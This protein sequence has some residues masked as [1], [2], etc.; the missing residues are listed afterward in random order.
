MPKLPFEL[1]PL[2]AH[3]YCRDDVRDGSRK[4]KQLKS[5]RDPDL[6]KGS[7]R[8]RWTD[9]MRGVGHV[10]RPSLVFSKGCD[11]G[12]S[13][14]TAVLISLAAFTINSANAGESWKGK[15]VYYKKNSTANV[16]EKN[17][18]AQGVVGFPE[19]VLEEDGDWVTLGSARMRKEYLMDSEEAYPY[20]SNLANKD[21]GDVFAWVGFASCQFERGEFKRSIKSFSRAIELA[22]DVA[23]THVNR[24]VA[25]NCVHDFEGAILDENRAIELDPSYARAYWARGF[26]RYSLGSTKKA[27]LDYDMAIQ[28]GSGEAKVYNDRS[29]VKYAL[30]DVQGAIED[31]SE[32]MR[33]DP[34]SG[35]A[36]NT[37]AWIYATSSDAKLRNG[38]LAVELASRS[39]ELS[40]S[41]NAFVLGTLAAAHAEVAEF[42]KAVTFLKRAIEL[43][44]QKDRAFRQKML[45]AFTERKPFRN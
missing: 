14:Q 36:L 45:E 19:I 23:A 42:D 39:N 29:S 24:G 40:R 3:C 18:D 26:A 20:F 16:G 10:F 9:G 7:V 33:L 21:A 27:L 41:S 32:A 28:L 6:L 25:K 5:K 43:A 12:P 11:M 44:P 8:A 37:L 17:V 30:G 1:F 4:G 13:V 38:P 35:R 31:A 34:D 22:P 15:R 2:A